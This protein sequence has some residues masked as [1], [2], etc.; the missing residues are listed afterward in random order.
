[1]KCF[2]CGEP[3]NRPK[4]SMALY[5]RNG[6]PFCSLT[7]STRYR[8]KI[9]SE[10]M[11][12]TNRKHAS[13]RMT[14]NNPMRNEASRQKMTATLKA[15]GHSPSIRGGNGKPPTEAEVML[16]SLLGHFGFQMQVSVPTGFP[17]GTGPGHYKIDCANRRLKIAIE[18]DG[19]SHCGKR[20]MSDHR[21]D[22]FLTGCGWT[23]YRFSNATILNSPAMVMFTISKSLTSTPTP[24]TG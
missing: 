20:L 14:A 11:A 16:N 24:P 12:A 8:G 3:V 21:K 2:L 5:R 17:K 13:A 9:S 15:I 19:V 7:C 1:M 6:R 22:A 23:V 10:T 18:A 4:A